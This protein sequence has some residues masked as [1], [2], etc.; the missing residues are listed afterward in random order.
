MF[1]LQLRDYATQKMTDKE[2]GSA[3]SSERHK[4][5]LQTLSNL[6]GWS[7]A[8]QRLNKHASH[9]YNEPVQAW[10]DSARHP[11]PITCVVVCVNIYCIMKLH[12]MMAQRKTIY[13]HWKLNSDHGKHAVPVIAMLIEF[14][15]WT[16][17][18]RAPH[19]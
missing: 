9:D 4:G 3:R 17:V 19:A 10:S 2:R 12:F 5:P 16:I 1:L 11:K 14:M 18:F 8:S 13:P 6:A 15:C 7:W